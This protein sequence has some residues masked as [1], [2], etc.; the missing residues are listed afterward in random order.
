MRDVA[1]G[2]ASATDAAPPE[3]A[4]L[5]SAAP[6]ARP[7]PVLARLAALLEQA[8]GA[9]DRAARL[10]PQEALPEAGEWQPAR[11]DDGVLQELRFAAPR[12]GSGVAYRVLGGQVQALETG[13]LLAEGTRV[14]FDAYLNCFYEHYW[15]SHAPVGDLQLRLFGLGVL[16]V[17]AFRGLPDGTAYRIGQARLQLDPQGRAA[18][19]FTCDAT[20]AGA[21]RI[22]FEIFAPK[23]ATLLAGRI[24]T[25]APP[26]R[27]VR[28]GI[29]LCTFNRERMLLATLQRLTRAPYCEWA[30]PRIV[31]V[32]QGRPFAMPEMLALLEAQQARIT[33]V[34]QPNLGGV[35]GFTRAAMEILRNEAPEE[36]D[37]GP[38]VGPGIGPPCS[39]VLFMDDDIEFDPDVLVTT[40]AFAARTTRPTVIGGAMMDLFRPTIIYEAGAVVDVENIIRAALHNR[41]IEDPATLHDLAR[42]VPCHFNGWWYC[43]IPAEM[44]RR[45]GLPLPIFIRG[46]DMEFGVRLASRDVPTVSLP[47]ISVWHEPFYAKPPGWQL[48]YDLRNRLI[49]ASCH[50]TLA[51]LDRPATILRRLVDSLLKHDYMHAALLIRAVEDFLAGPAILDTPMDELHRDISALATANLPLRPASAAGI[52]PARWRAP[53]HRSWRWLTLLQG[54]AALQAGLVRRKLRPELVLINQWH[55][56]MTMGVSQYALSDAMRSYIQVYR[57]DRARMRDGLRRGLAAILRY[58]REGAAAAR[59]WQAAQ[60]GLAT[61]PRWEAVLRMAPERAPDAAVQDLA[62]GPR[63]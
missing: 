43:A 45:H 9:E 41:S 24:E 10:D 33:V 63:G 30:S 52:T 20:P 25:L 44:F 8:L 38:A 36:P 27:P 49:F 53:P 7:H 50:P 6:D 58:R 12:C 47:P 23:G 62:G 2:P 11:L 17:E 1:P 22:F 42:E 5:A 56:W 34:T 55:P 61:W 16:L 19:H 46:D 4:A 18:A 14:S 40:H 60:H 13:L 21:G 51:K 57:Y 37:A 3:D 15:S 26:V 28:L 39:H 54:L 32:N 48:Y 59:R 31:V 29:G 35:G